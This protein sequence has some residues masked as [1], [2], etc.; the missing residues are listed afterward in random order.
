MNDHQQLIY[1]WFGVCFFV[2]VIL[3]FISR[4]V[5]FTVFV[6]RYFDYH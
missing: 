1:V 3:I 6:F 5:V 2:V 4:F